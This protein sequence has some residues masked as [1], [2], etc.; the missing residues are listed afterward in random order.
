MADKNVMH[1][2]ELKTEGNNLF[3]FL[4]YILND[5]FFSFLSNMPQIAD[6]LS[7]ARSFICVN[8][9]CTRPSISITG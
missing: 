6:T 1:T 8:I 3:M 2:L 7:Y 4:N 5:V 9:E